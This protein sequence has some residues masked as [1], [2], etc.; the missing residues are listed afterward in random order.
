VT[1]ELYRELPAKNFTQSRTTKLLTNIL[2]STWCAQAITI[3]AVSKITHAG[4]P[5]RVSG[6]QGRAAAMARAA[7][8]D[9]HAL[10]AQARGR[11]L[12]RAQEMETEQLLRRRCVPVR[13]VKHRRLRQSNKQ[14]SK[15][16][17]Q[18]TGSTAVAETVQQIEIQTWSG[19]DA[20]STDRIAH[21]Q[22]QQG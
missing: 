19:T 18:D 1:Q 11:T 20:K 13:G 10:S 15:P 4:K 9:L 12:S 22:R 14:K 7:V 21:A 5:Y 3:T 6:T 17:A 16:R 2:S 8:G